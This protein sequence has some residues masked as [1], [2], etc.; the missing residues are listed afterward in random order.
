MALSLLRLIAAALFARGLAVWVTLPAL[1]EHTAAAGTIHHSD[2][3]RRQASKTANVKKDYAVAH[4][5][6]QTTKQAANHTQGNAT[7]AVNSTDH[8]AT[9]AGKATPRLELGDAANHTR[10]NGTTAVN[11]ADHNATL[12]GKAHHAENYQAH[13]ATESAHSTVSHWTHLAT[14]KAS[15]WTHSSTERENH[16]ASHPGHPPTK[17]ASLWTHSSTEGETHTASHH[18]YL[19]TKKASHWTHSSAERKANTTAKNATV[20]NVNAAK[21]T[22][23]NATA[24]NATSANAT[25]TNATAASLGAT[26]RATVTKD[27]ALGKGGGKATPD[28]AFNATPD[29]AVNA[30]DAAVNASD[31]V[32]IDTSGIKTTVYGD[33]QCPCMAIVN[34]DGYANMSLPGADAEVDV[35]TYPADFGSTCQAWDV[36][37]W[38]D[39]DK[40]PQSYG[41]KWCFVD[42]CTCSLP[43]SPPDGYL[44]SATV[45]G[46]PVHVS[47][48]TCGEVAE[49][50][51]VAVA[52][53]SAATEQ[54]CAVEP[55]PLVV[56]LSGCTCVGIAELLGTRRLYLDGAWVDYPGGAGSSCAAWDEN[57]HPD[58]SAVDPP[59]WCRQPWCYVDPCNCGVS[60]DKATSLPG[61]TF[62][63][64]PLYY[65]Y[66]T[67]GGADMYTNETVKANYTGNCEAWPPGGPPGGGGNSMVLASVIV[68]VLLVALLAFFM[69]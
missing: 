64:K 24:A 8:N 17:K 19:A 58:C 46:R 63:G 50:A 2:R 3:R 39:P 54:I 38:E 52:V 41:K 20:P 57:R 30:S 28:D 61:A 60:S 37:R 51:E 13:S 56:G 22:V 15:H 47:Y 34:V 18:A 62:Q 48:A 31:A 53:D 11:A 23:A 7:T 35:A 44:P 42:P 1:R 21:A 16:T 65:S 27:E 25:V 68:G 69:A 66:T 43:S 29:A 40:G 12:A 55:D 67:C 45:N 32:D 10:G 59:A 49:V 4:V 9:L 14:K 5:K 6:N 26:I 36:G 33:M